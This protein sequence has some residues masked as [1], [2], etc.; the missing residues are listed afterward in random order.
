MKNLQ[1]SA[2][3]TQELETSSSD[4]NCQF[5][6][7]FETYLKNRLVLLGCFS[8]EGL[9]DPGAMRGFC[10]VCHKHKPKY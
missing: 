4:F 3:L 7:F 9:C 10:F 1:T 5:F 8:L 2:I 6:P